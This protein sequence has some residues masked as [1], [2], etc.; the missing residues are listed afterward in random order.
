MSQKDAFAD[1]Y[2]GVQTKVEEH[3]A[4]VCEPELL[5]QAVPARG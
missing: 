4:R 5:G 2:M 1:T 3:E